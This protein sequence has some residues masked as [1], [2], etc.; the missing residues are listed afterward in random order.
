MKRS[1]AIETLCTFHILHVEMVLDAFPIALQRFLPFRSESHNA[2]QQ[3]LR[4]M[5]RTEMFYLHRSATGDIG[6]TRIPH[7][8]ISHYA[9]HPDLQYWNPPKTP[10]HSNNW[11]YTSKPKKPSTDIPASP[12]FTRTCDCHKATSSLVNISYILYI[13]TD[14]QKHSPKI[15]F[16][17]DSP[18][19]IH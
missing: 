10:L 7:V 9:Q 19:H 8:V 14:S 11:R 12:G 3:C 1:A 4:H 16:I 6:G 17:K 2:V 15:H 18:D 5:L 13:F